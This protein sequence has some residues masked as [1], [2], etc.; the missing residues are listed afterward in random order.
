M[1]KLKPFLFIFLISFA[2]CGY[3]TKSLLSENIKTVHIAP[4]QNAINLSA[5]ISDKD[6]FR[7][8]RP[9]IEVEITNALINRFIF[10]GNLQVREAGSAD[11][12]VEAKL[13]DYRRDPLRYSKGDD[14]Q[15]YR[16]SVYLDIIVTQ[17]SDK[18]VLW[19]DHGLV[20]DT[21]FFIAGP[22]AVSEDEAA[23]KAVEDIARRV[24][25]KT[26]EVW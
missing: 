4:V 23:R 19:R 16:L 21:T 2:G 13:I 3:T 10:D 20:G 25:D 12:V 6:E 7:V 26:I 5:E 1:V 8:Y 17:A 9:G 14:V 22:R 15:E 18:K 11:A 24:V